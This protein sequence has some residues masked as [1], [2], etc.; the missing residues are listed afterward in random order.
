MVLCTV[1]YRHF[2]SAG[3]DASL[4][5]DTSRVLA[6][7]GRSA[8]PFVLYD[9]LCDI[10]TAA[11]YRLDAWYRRGFDVIIVGGTYIRLGACRLD[12]SASGQ[13]S[14][15]GTMLCSMYCRYLLK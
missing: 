1:L 4:Y 13:A 8:G 3:P 15:Q 5:D 10:A 6:Q 2:L 7:W 9:K 14:K 12:C 11:L